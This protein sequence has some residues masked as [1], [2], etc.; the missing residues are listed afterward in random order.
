M[1]DR[2]TGARFDHDPSLDRPLGESTRQFLQKYRA[3]DEFRHGYNLGN[4]QFA[5]PDQYS[6]L[7]RRRAIWVQ[8]FVGRLF[9]V[10]SVNEA[11]SLLEPWVGWGKTHSEIW[12]PYWNG[13]HGGEDTSAHYKRTRELFD[14]VPIPDEIK[15]YQ[16]DLTDEDL[17]SMADSLLWL[18]R[19]I[20]ETIYLFE[21]VARPVSVDTVFKA[22]RI[23]NEPVVPAGGLEP[24]IINK[25]SVRRVEHEGKNYIAFD[26][27]G[28]PADSA[29][30]DPST[31]AEWERWNQLELGN[32]IKYLREDR[33]AKQKTLE[34]GIVH[35]FHLLG[36]GDTML[37]GPSVAN[38]GIIAV[39]DTTRFYQCPLVS[40]IRLDTEEFTPEELT[41]VEQPKP[42]E[43]VVIKPPTG[44]VTQ[45]TYASMEEA[46]D[47]VRKQI[48]QEFG[49]PQ[50]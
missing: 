39:N 17:R 16:G 27:E 6:E 20:R 37:F 28:M 36:A 47:A 4:M 25:P 46:T 45:Q 9:D 21:D 29:S 49:S 35:G 8:S 38:I 14:E 41:K 18:T 32:H 40:D 11:D 10:Q 22:Q 30:L 48:A 19:D 31:D 44:E 3:T 26:F 34:A 24:D 1:L 7:G 43:V 33:Q 23:M 15:Q 5:N 2:D 13:D 42:V 50:Q 12:A